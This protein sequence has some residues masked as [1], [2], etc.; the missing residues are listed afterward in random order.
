[1]LR[2]TRER[3]RERARESERE[4]LADLPID[5]FEIFPNFVLFTTLPRRMN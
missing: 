1:M 3:E 4:R 2:E 5:T